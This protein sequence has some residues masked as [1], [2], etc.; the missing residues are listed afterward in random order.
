MVDFVVV[1]ESF[2]DVVHPGHRIFLSLVWSHDVTLFFWQ[3][4]G[5]NDVRDAFLING[6]YPLKM[7]DTSFF[8]VVTAPARP[9]LLR[10]DLEGIQRSGDCRFVVF[11]VQ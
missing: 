5:M 4:R 9:A 3:E 11:G 7:Y 2:T 8:I 6:Q 1:K 10:A